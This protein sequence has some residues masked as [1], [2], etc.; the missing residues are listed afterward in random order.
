M[1]RYQYRL[2]GV[3]DGCASPGNAIVALENK[4]GSGKRVTIR[5]FEA[6]LKTA[7]DDS[8]L[9][10]YSS[11]FGMARGTLAPD[12]EIQP[13]PLDSNS[14]VPSGLVFYAGGTFT[15]TNT[16]GR[17]LELAFLDTSATAT[18][19]AGLRQQKTWGG[20]CYGSWAARQR[21]GSTAVE[22]V[23]VSPGEAWSLYVEN[24]SRVQLHRF[25]LIVRVVGG[26]TF[27]LSEIVLSDAVGASMMSIKNDS[28]SD[29]EVVS[30]AYTIL[31][32]TQAT[33]YLQVVPYAT[34]SADIVATPT[35]TVAI[36]KMDSANP[37]P[38][39]WVRAVKNSPLAP[40]DV[41]QEYAA[42]AGWGSPKGFNYLGTKDFIGPVYRS[43]FP[44]LRALVGPITGNLYPDDR[45]YGSGHRTCDLLF[46]GAGVVIRPG[47]GIAVAGT[48]ESVSNITPTSVGGHNPIEFAITFD[49]EN[50]VQPYLTLTGLQSGSDIVVLEAGTG[51]FL[52]QI[53]AYSGT[54]WVWAYDSDIVT[55][56]DV[57]VYKPGYVPL[58][59]RNVTTPAQG[60]SIPIVQTPDR[61]YS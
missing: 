40:S 49:I 50:E 48:A 24:L 18:I 32:S 42:A 56:V 26:G 41:P 25:E 47:E 14:T 19:V 15:P 27:T 34:L 55:S 37:D 28:A 17:A 8:F 12:R 57:C 10:A 9:N 60:L 7:S 13:S 21:G 35:N 36:S 2:C 4:G 3:F 16:F 54:S 52:Q 38:T 23:I 5:S 29:V 1:A 30:I 43:F 53:D 20:R 39:T 51:N 45:R 44:E 6:C 22:R 46:A 31:G 11:L 61:N 59:L 33:P 58:A